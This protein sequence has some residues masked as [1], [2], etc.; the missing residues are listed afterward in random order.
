[1]KT[2][3]E[4]QATAVAPNED[5]VLFETNRSESEVIRIAK[6]GYKGRTFM[7]LRLFFKDKNGEYRPTKKGITVSE[8]IFPVLADG[9]LSVQE[10]L[11]SA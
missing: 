5:E 8:E 10:I 9:I 4:T 3:S 6:R 11:A 2:K 7:D 1:M